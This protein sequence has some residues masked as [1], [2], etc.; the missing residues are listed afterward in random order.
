[1]SR[2]IILLVFVACSCLGKAQTNYELTKI[3]DFYSFITLNISENNPLRIRSDGIKYTS[4]KIEVQ[5]PWENPISVGYK[6]PDGLINYL[7]T[8]ISDHADEGFNGSFSTQLSVFEV[9]QTELNVDFGNFNGYV[10]ITML[11]A[12]PLNNKV[13]QKLNKTSGRCDKP[14]MISYVIWR[15]FL[16]NPKPPRE[17]TKVEHLVVHHSAGN[18][19]D[20]NYVNIVRNIYLLHTQTNGWDD[21]GYNFLV[22]PNGVIFNGRDPQGVADDDNI[23]GAHFCGKN[24]N[25]M[26]VCMMGNFMDVRPTQAA[27]FSLKY[28]LAWKLKK[29]GIDAF[30]QT[31]HPQ[32]SGSLLNNLCGH[33]D[34]CNTDCPGDSLYALLPSIKAEAARIADSCGLVLNDKN[35]VPGI[36]ITLFPNP[37]SGTITIHTANYLSHPKIKIYGL[38][39]NLIYETSFTPGVPIILT[40][41]SGF[42]YCKIFDL[43]SLIFKSHLI[44]QN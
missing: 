44:F 14:E 21:I 27:I 1:M 9:P 23:L 5:Q 25:T 22:A 13:L 32:P 3:N 6:K 26:G 12:P 43:E 20:T 34:G 28:L 8:K 39:G 42:Y 18:N 19:A 31:K 33:R 17:A 29:D 36:G 4:L 10:K 7:T 37:S 11:Y 40:L 16:P 24:Q 41:T 38:P 15:E 2:N 30:G 35:S